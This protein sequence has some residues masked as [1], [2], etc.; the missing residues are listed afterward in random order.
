M[1]SSNVWREWQMVLRRPRPLQGLLWNHVER[2]RIKNPLP[3]L[4]CIDFWGSFHL[5]KNMRCEVNFF[6]LCH[7]GEK[8]KDMNTTRR[9]EIRRQLTSTKGITRLQATTAKNFQAPKASINHFQSHLSWIIS[10]FSENEIIISFR[11]FIVGIESSWTG[12]ASQTYWFQVSKDGLGRKR[13][14]LDYKRKATSQYNITII[15]AIYHSM[16]WVQG[17][18]QL[19][20]I[21]SNKIASK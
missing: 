14:L 1:A 9:T 8:K 4:I 18:A 6:S 2:N 3:K 12:R 10:R 20:F 11:L 21:C 17:K 13:F 16:S 5:H 19:P 7:R 15:A